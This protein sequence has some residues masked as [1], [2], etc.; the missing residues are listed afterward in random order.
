MAITHTMTPLGGKG[1]FFEGARWRD[2]AWWVSDLYAHEVLRI[3][4]DGATRVIARVD[5][6]PSGLGWLADGT[7]LVVSMKDRRVIAVAADGT[8]RV[9]ADIRALTACYA[10][11]MVTDARGNAWVGNLG[12]DLFVG[13]KP[14]PAD[15]VHV[16][17]DGTARIVAADLLFPN[18][19]VV[20]P[21]GQ[22]LIVA[23]TFG[24]RLSA[25][26]IRPDGSLGDRRVWAEVGRMPPWDELHSLL[27]T[28]IM[29][30]GCAIEA[31]GCVWM[32]DAMGARV[33][34][35]A[36]G[37]GIIAEI[38]A[39]P[40]MGLYSCALGGADGNQLLVC[41]APDYDDLKRAAVRE[42][43][44][45]IIDLPAFMVSKA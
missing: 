41:C 43:Q 16:A 36:E 8:T 20:T 5:G 22:T 9:H 17:P 4:P 37:R 32:A 33:V 19:M 34:R 30:D 26:A 2:G 10:N 18:G 14:R 13:E 38:A 45:F 7:L 35:V 3:A 39:P 27:Q 40:G 11:D 15:L 44:L 23:E 12:F 6:Q 29:P 1:H 25:F 31:Q 42:A 21:D 28:D 24:A